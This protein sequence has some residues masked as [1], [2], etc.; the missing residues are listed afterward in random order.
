MLWF[1]ELLKK[2]ERAQKKKRTE[3]ETAFYGLSDRF[4]CIGNIFDEE[5]EHPLYSKATYRE[6]CEGLEMLNT[7]YLSHLSP[8]EMTGPPNLPRRRNILE[9]DGEVLLLN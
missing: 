7:H 5:Q 3:S 2:S 1:G 9:E 6:L 4:H 8:G